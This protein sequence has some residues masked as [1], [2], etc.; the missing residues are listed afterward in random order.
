LGTDV[1]D[2]S[3]CRAAGFGWRRSAKG[4]DDLIIV[5]ALA[6]RSSLVHQEEAETTCAV[7]GL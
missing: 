6:G 2:A 4:H 1:E 3:V 7:S 5:A